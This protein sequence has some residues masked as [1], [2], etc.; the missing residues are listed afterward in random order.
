MPTLSL[1]LRRRMGRTIFTTPRHRHLPKTPDMS[2]LSLLIWQGQTRQK[3]HKWWLQTMYIRKP[4]V[5]PRSPPRK[6]LATGLEK[7][8]SM[9][10]QQGRLPRKIIQYK[11]VPLLFSVECK[12]VNKSLFLQVLFLESRQVGVIWSCNNLKTF[13]GLGEQRLFV[14]SIRR[15]G[16]MGDHTHMTLTPF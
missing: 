6:L 16:G 9:A 2:M 13:H 5:L 14:F 3:T 4:S 12:Y 1:C 15:E 7:R 10:L 8:I 11:C